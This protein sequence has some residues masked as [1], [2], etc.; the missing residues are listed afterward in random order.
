MKRVLLTY[1]A[2]VAGGLAVG[3]GAAR[4]ALGDMDGLLILAIGL[5]AIVYG[6][7]EPW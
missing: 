1:F 3:Y 7:Q 5:L 2:R 6:L 4:F